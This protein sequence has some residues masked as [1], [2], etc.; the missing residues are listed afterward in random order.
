MVGLLAA[1]AVSIQKLRI[2][3]QAVVIGE[4]FDLA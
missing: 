1:L 3:K 4:L 2:S